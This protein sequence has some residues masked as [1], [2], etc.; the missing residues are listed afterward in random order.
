MYLNNAYFGNGVW[1]CSRCGTTLLWK[2]ASDVTVG[3]AATIAGML[4]SQAT[5]I[6]LI[7]WIMQFQGETLF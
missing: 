6:Q 7:I 2:N 3:E 5:I 4:R 1:G